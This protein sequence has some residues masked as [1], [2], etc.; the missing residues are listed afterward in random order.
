MEKKIG[1]L[2]LLTKKFINNNPDI[3]FMHADKGNVVVAMDKAEYIAKMETML[4]DVDTYINIKRNSVNRITISLK[5]ILKRWSQHPFCQKIGVI[6]SLTDRVLLLSHPSFYTKNL[7]KIIRIL[8]N[9]GYPLNL[10]FSTINKRLH[11]KFSNQNNQIVNNKKVEKKQIFFTVP[12]IAGISERIKNFLKKTNII[13]IAYKGINKLSNYIRVQKD[14]LPH[15]MFHTDVV[16]KMECRDC[17]ASYVGQTGRTL[18]TRISEHRNH[19]NRNTDQKSVITEH[20]LEHTHDFDWDS[21]KILDQEQIL[22][23]RLISE[24]IFIRKQKNGLNIQSDTDSLT[25]AYDFLF[26]NN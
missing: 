2:Y 11:K 4:R 25:K 18:K 22:S 7:D 10:I 3:L 24:M 23:K 14:K 16:Y 20:R 19:I 6:V 13:K 26:D 1:S 8:L 5:D 17:D 9:N 12:F 21:V 15:F